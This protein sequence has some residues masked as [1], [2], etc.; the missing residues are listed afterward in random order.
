M[1]QKVTLLAVVSL[2]A[3]TLYGDYAVNDRGTWPESWPRELDPLRTQARTFEG[4]KELLRHYAIPFNSREDF[5]AAWPHI[6]KVKTKGAPILLRKGRSFWLQ[7]SPGVCIHTP[8]V[9][10]TPD[11]TKN[12][13]LENT[14]YLEL[15]VDGT[16]VDLNRIP[17][18][19]ETPIIDERFN[20]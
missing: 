10:F 9:D 1:T 4:P 5:E 15:I 20:E 7:E 19:R 8:P 13:R 2:F 16:I 17:L 6:L 14:V 18:P 11:V 12:A 3:L